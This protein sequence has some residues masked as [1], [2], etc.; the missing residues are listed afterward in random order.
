MTNQAN[1]ARPHQRK[2]KR[3]S[4]VS[5]DDSFAREKHIVVATS[6]RPKSTTTTRNN[7]DNTPRARVPGLPVPVTRSP[8]VQTPQET[9]EFVQAALTAQF[10]HHGYDASL[11]SYRNSS[12]H[13]PTRGSMD[14]NQTGVESSPGG[15]STSAYLGRS[16]YLGDELEEHE[17]SAVDAQ[18]VHASLTEDD[19]AVLNLRRAFDLPGRAVCESLVA[20]FVARCDPWMPVVEPRILQDLLHGCMADKPI[21]LLQAVLMAGRWVWYPLNYT[22]VSH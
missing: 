4:V 12:A 11:A 1:G 18:G 3:Y 22:T 6:E 19:W 20:T 2:R 7:V 15:Q 13:G 14:R 10:G 9:V 16:K 21:L 5:S 8:Q 17:E